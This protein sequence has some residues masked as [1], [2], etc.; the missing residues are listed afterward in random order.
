MADYTV[1]RNI[2]RAKRTITKK[3]TV[4]ERIQSKRANA[5]IKHK[6]G[7]DIYVQSAMYIDSGWRDFIGG[8][9]KIVS[10]KADKDGN[11]I[12]VVVKENVNTQYNYENLLRQQEKLA[13]ECGNRRGKRDPDWYGIGGWE[14]ENIIAGDPNLRE[15]ENGG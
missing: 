11:Y 8:K 1:S 14:K 13:K 3:K 10:I 9:C 6:V 5:R 12:W 15:L 2:D 7:D 4:K